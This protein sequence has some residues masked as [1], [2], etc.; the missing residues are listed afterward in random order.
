MCGL[1]AAH[2]EQ[3]VLDADLLQREPRVA[4]C[5]LE[6]PCWTNVVLHGIRLRPRVESQRAPAR[7]KVHL[8]RVAVLQVHLGEDGVLLLVLGLGPTPHWIHAV[9]VVDL[10]AL[11]LGHRIAVE[12]RRHRRWC[13]GRRSRRAHTLGGQ[14]LVELTLARREVRVPVLGALLLALDEVCQLLCSTFSFI[15][16]KVAH[17]VGLILLDLCPALPRLTLLLVGA[18][19]R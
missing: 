13:D 3:R 2:N 8:P 4:P 18:D 14:L 9:A 1:H 17:P 16:A 6:V 5:Q 15:T 11:V 12:G 10:H 7:R 19:Q